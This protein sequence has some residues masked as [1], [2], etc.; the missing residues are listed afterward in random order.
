MFGRRLLFSTSHKIV[1]VQQCSRL[2]SSVQVTKYF[3]DDRTLQDFLSDSSNKHIK[4]IQNPIKRPISDSQ[5]DAGD[6]LSV[7][8]ETYGCQMNASDSEIVRSVFLDAGHTMSDSLEA[9]DVI[10][11]NTCAIRG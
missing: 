8:I 5:P 6:S 9:A 1:N 4:T 3:N 2:S 11:A 10:V 7:F